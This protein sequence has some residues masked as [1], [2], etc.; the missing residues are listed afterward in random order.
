MLNPVVVRY[1]AIATHTPARA[2][3][4]M[5]VLTSLRASRE[6]GA[7]GVMFIIWNGSVGIPLVMYIGESTAGVAAASA[8]MAESAKI[9]K[10]VGACIVWDVEGRLLDW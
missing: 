9:E 1:E 7:A 8:P 4:A 5:Q 6:F 10:M 2:D 3:V